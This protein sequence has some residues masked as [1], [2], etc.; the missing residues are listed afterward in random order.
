MPRMALNFMFLGLRLSSKAS[1]Y[2]IESGA[3]DCNR[4]IVSGANT[5]KSASTARTR[6]IPKRSLAYKR[7]A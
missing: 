1:L 4:A 2:V 7:R 6:W 5:A 3:E